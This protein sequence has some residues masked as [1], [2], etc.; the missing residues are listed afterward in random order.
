M[1]SLESHQL[2][3]TLRQFL[4]RIGFKTG[5]TIWLRI[6][7][8]HPLEAAPT[9]W[10]RYQTRSG[11]K[12]LR[13]Y[14]LR[15]V[16]TGK[17]LI[18][19]LC[20]WQ[21]RDASGKACWQPSSGS[22]RR[23]FMHLLKLSLMGATVSFYPNQPQN[24]IH[25]RDVQRCYCLFYEIDSLSLLE[26][27]AT[28]E[29]V[30]RQTGLQPA[31]IV[32]TGGKS[33]HVY[34][35]LNQPA[36][37]K[38]W[39]LLNRKLAIVVGAEA[40]P[41]I[42][43][44]ARAMRLPSMMRR[45]WLGDRL[46][47]PIPITLDAESDQQYSL[48][49]MNQ[50]LNS[51]GLFPHELSEQRWRTWVKLLRQAKTDDTVDPY[52]AVLDAAPS[53]RPD[54]QPTVG[55]GEDAEHDPSIMPQKRRDSGAFSHSHSSSI[56]DSVPLIMCLTQA[57][58]QLLQ[59]GESEGNRNNAGYRLARNLIGTARLLDGEA[60]RFYPSPDDLFAQYCERCIPQLDADEA[61][62]IWQSASRTPA[63]ASRPLDS[64]LSSIAWW[65]RQEKWQ[66][67]HDRPRKKRSIAQA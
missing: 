19:Q 14:L 26:Q 20:E 59:Q 42:C 50:A 33:L 47:D 2:K 40:D 38:Q 39:L 55:R 25:N 49:G 21:G 3:Q 61:A 23:G 58:Q 13:H 45:K 52:H 30:K 27:H 37:P 7:W 62:A 4:D 66:S 51:T 54:W 46:A 6:S 22:K 24:G 56:S 8:N 44:V 15:G 17:G 5:S 41:A 60:I 32:Y 31:A 36:S 16:V 64:I 18:A 48:K 35:R 67:V 34:F 12:Q 43:N 65:Q 63:S 10:S 9:A 11:K 29:R 1:Q 53:T 28:L 57:D